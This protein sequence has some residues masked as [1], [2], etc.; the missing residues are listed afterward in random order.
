M[1]QLDDA[2]SLPEDK[3]GWDQGLLVYP[4]NLLSL[5]MYLVVKLYLSNG[6]CDWCI[7]EIT[8]LWDS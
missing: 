1:S 3:F 5:Y 4:Y 2:V 8:L 6:F 7:I